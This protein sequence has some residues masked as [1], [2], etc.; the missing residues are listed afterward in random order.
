MNSVILKSGRLLSEADTSAPLNVFKFV[1]E[2]G[3]GGTE[4]QVLKLSEQFTPDRFSLAFGCIRRKG[5]IAQAYGSHGWSISEYPISG[6]AKINTGRQMLRLARELRDRKCQVMHSYNFYANVFSIPAARLA[7]VPCIVASIRDMGVY[8]TPMQKR[9]Q[10]WACSLADRIL[11]NAYAIRDWLIADGYPAEKI[12]VIRNGAHVPRLDVAAER[13]RIRSELGIPASAKVAIMVSRLNPKKGVEDFID[14]LPRV[15]AQLPDAWLVIAGNVVLASPGHEDAYLKELA[16]RA[17]RLGAPERI[18][19]TGLRRDVPSLLA[20]ADVSVLPSYSEGLPNSV[21]EAMAS[22]LPVV[23]TRVGGV[24]ELVR[25]RH[26]GFLVPPGD[27]DSLAEALVTVLANPFLGK[28]LGEAGRV[29]IQSEFSF[30]KMFRETVAL[31]A[32]VLSEKQTMARG[33]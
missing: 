22:G 2:F 25:P 15:L 17:R 24:P 30:E 29:Q 5:L 31:Y 11:V 7:G 32:R 20:C 18:L 16:E 3:L 23:A 4:L 14:T 10:R 33:R 19:F 21:I 13:K 1:T 27:V 12:H 8:M 28:R 26:T 6:F 9:V